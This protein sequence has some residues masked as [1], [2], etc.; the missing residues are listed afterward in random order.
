MFS[1]RLPHT[2]SCV[3]DK[4][5]RNFVFPTAVHQIPKALL[6]SRDWC[7][8][9]HQN[10]INVKQEPKGAGDLRMDLHHKEVK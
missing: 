7:S 3:G 1:F 10:P 6:G 9:P 8:P 5:H 4:H 2:V